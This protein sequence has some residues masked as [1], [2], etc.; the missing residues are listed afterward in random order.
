MPAVGYLKRL[1]N[2]GRFL[3]DKLITPINNLYK[4][5]KDVINGVIGTVP[6]GNYINT[7]LNVASRVS[8]V[9]SPIVSSLTRDSE[10]LDQLPNTPQKQSIRN[11]HF[12]N[13]LQGG[14]TVPSQQMSLKRR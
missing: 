12:T 1:K 5:N 2:I 9:A 10:V 6:F 3:N 13:V 4:K 14:P 7:G 8:D 11:S